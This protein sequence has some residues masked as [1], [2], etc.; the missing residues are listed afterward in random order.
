MH[1]VLNLKAEVH[2]PAALTRAAL[3]ALERTWGAPTDEDRRAP[4]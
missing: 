4:A 3:T 2:D 1:V